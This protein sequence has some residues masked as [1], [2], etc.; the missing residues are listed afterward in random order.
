MTTAPTGG[1]PVPE[2]EPTAWEL[3][4]I[5]RDIREDLRDMKRNSITRDEW[6]LAQEATARQFVEVNK[7]V[8]GSLMEH[9]TIEGQIDAVKKD[10]QEV[11]RERAE[12]E[13]EKRKDRSSRI[14]AIALA[15]VAAVFAF[16]SSILQGGVAG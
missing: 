11:R 3:M 10:I 4:R 1:R 14:F 15:G 8:D 5:L 9:K 6:A 2:T 7:R 16:I 12:D 13:K